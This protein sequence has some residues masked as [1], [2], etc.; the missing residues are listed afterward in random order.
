VVPTPCEK[1]ADK[2][3]ELG[4]AVSEKVQEYVGAMEKVRRLRVKSVRV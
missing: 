2:V 3:A 4:K 1:G